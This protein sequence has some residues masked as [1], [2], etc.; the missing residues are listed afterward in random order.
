MRYKKI[1]GGLNVKL[2]GIMSR[3][4]N[5]FILELHHCF[6]LSCGTFLS[7]HMLDCETMVP[8]VL[9]YKYDSVFQYFLDI[10]VSATD[11]GTM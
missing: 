7:A 8:M 6:V 1:L 11:R 2:M 9:L 5:I 3:N 10:F 4:H